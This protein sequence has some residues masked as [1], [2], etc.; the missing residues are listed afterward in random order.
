MTISASVYTVVRN[1]LS[2]LG[3][4]NGETKASMKANDGLSLPGLRHYLPQIK[5]SLRPA[6]K[7]ARNQERDLPS[8]VNSNLKV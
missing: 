1:M 6:F 5:G 8:V 7:V 4:R 3:D 2:D